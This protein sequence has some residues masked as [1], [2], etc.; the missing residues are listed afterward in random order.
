MFRDISAA[1]ISKVESRAISVCYPSTFCN[2][3]LAAVRELSQERFCERAVYLDQITAT[4]ASR[5]TL[6][7]SGLLFGRQVFWGCD[8]ESEDEISPSTS[9]LGHLLAPELPLGPRGNHLFHGEL[10][11]LP[12]DTDL[13]DFESSQRP[14]AGDSLV[15]VRKPDKF[16]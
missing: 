6:L 15:S 14:F 13:L 7:D 8:L 9:M 2:D 1:W 3:I 16:K 5:E 4:S 12:I 11:A 10:D